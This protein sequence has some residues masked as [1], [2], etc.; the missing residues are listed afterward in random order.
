MLE[1]ILLVDDTEND[2]LLFKHALKQAGLDDP[3]FWIQ[4]SQQALAYL[5]GAGHYADR[6]KFP[7]PNI[8]LLDMRMPGLDGIA[9]LKWVKEQPHL[10][11]LVVVMVSHLQDLK[12]I[13]LA[14]EM[15]AQSFIDKAGPAE[16][17]QNFVRFAKGLSR[18]TKPLPAA[19]K[20]GPQ[21][22]S[23]AGNIAA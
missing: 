11:E 10:S 3:I 12:L 16:E 4:D 7:V 15:G 13:K 18:V 20:P 2:A 1:R 8:L 9:L 19:L 22:Q 21:N 6:E 23:A 17:F 5:K 14:Y